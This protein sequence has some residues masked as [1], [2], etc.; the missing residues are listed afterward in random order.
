MACKSNSVVLEYN[1]AI[2]D[3]AGFTVYCQRYEVAWRYRAYFCPYVAYSA[4]CFRDLSASQNEAAALPAGAYVFETSCITG[5]SPPNNG[6]DFALDGSLVINF[7]EAVEPGSGNIVL[8]PLSLASQYRSIPIQDDL[9]VTFDL[10]NTSMTISPND[11]L[12]ASEVARTNLCPINAVTLDDCKGQI[13]DITLASGVLRRVTSTPLLAQQDLLEPLQPAGSN[14]ETYRL[15]ESGTSFCQA[16]PVPRL[17][18][19]SGFLD[20]TEAAFSSAFGYAEMEDTELPIVNVI[21]MGAAATS[22]R[23]DGIDVSLTLD[24]AGTAFCVAVRS[25]LPQPS[26]FMVAAGQIQTCA[27]T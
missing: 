21:T 6:Q 13:W 27:S 8:T 18:A 2:V 17:H 22:G 3:P 20:S 24:E 19:N 1:S 11:P 25:G 15:D 26:R 7:S 9:Q 10:L 16:F 4:G 14:G 23:E 5:F 12:L